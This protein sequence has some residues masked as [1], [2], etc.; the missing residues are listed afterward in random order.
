MPRP[1]RAR[2]CSL[3]GQP[4]R[5]PRP[6]AASG[7]F[8]QP[9]LGGPHASTTCRAPQRG[10]D[11]TSSSPGR[12][13]PTS[14]WTP[15][16]TQG[17]CPLPPALL[18]GTEFDTPLGVS[19]TTTS[20]RLRW[21]AAAARTLGRS[22]SHCCPSHTSPRCALSDHTG[23]LARARAVTG[24]N[25]PALGHAHGWPWPW[26][27]PRRPRSTFPAMNLTWGRCLARSSTVNSC[28][29]SETDLNNSI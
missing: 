8:L 10:A 27:W 3:G 28:T 14:S 20:S 19:W 15:F 29:W 13:G 23:S 18:V 22:P 1:R 2:L 6:C 4:A 7:T 9:P 11:R 12:A 21:C 25:A 17:R 5:L 26:P 24:S 16:Q